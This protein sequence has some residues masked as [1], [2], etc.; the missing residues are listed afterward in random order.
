VGGHSNNGTICDYND[1]DY[2]S[3]NTLPQ[4]SRILMQFSPVESS[5]P[6]LPHSTDLAIIGAGPQALTLVTH[7]IQK[8]Q[9]MRNRFVVLDPSGTWMQQ[10]YQQFNALDIPHLRSPVVHHPAPYPGALRSFAENRVRELFP[11]YDLPGTQLF[12]DFCQ[13][14]IRQWQL[15]ERV[16]PAQVERIEPIT[17]RDRVRFRLWLAS[18]GSSTK[19]IVA[20]RVVLA[21]GG[22]IRQTPDWVSRIPE[23]YP[24]DRLNHSQQIN[25][26]GVAIAGER[27]LVVG[28]GLTS[29]HLA[30]GALSRGANVV[31]M[32]RRQLQ[33]KLFDA[34]PGWLG[35]KY[36]KGFAAEPDGQR[37]WEMVQQARNGGSLTPAMAALLRGYQSRGQ[38]TIREHCQVTE[39]RWQ[40][41]CWLVCCHSGELLE[42]DRLWLA[43]GTR[44]DAMAQPLL[45]E[46]AAAY[47][48]KMVNGWP[49]L[50][51]HLRWPGCELYVMGGLAA[52]QVGPVARNLFGAK[53][54]SERLVPALIKPSAL[55]R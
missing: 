6:P 26:H 35:P 1:Y 12:R 11:P 19:S 18:S 21:T 46:V 4:V 40:D 8:R 42:F 27:V 37:R 24:K 14:L 10:W 41:G 38:L 45:Q 53:L 48:P 55:M 54:A 5:S 31:L 39:A 28:G 51:E 32:M 52:L 36:L 50:D 3:H 44:L 30:L 20:R 7:L 9:T 22:G 17:H 13:A 33:E 29:G 15:L 23:P 16:L 43:T 2:H 47:P 49:I 25:L 34:D